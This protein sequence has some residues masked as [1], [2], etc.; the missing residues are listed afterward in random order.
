MIRQLLVAFQ[1]LA[2]GDV[3]LSAAYS[4]L[5]NQALV[6][7][8][9][10]ADDQVGHSLRSAPQRRKFTRDRRRRS[11]QTSIQPAAP[12]AFLF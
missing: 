9:A 2:R 7:V 3:L 4:C 11:P 12:G 10:Y 1:A 8:A 5:G 6:L